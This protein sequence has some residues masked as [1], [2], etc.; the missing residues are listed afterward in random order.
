MSST[1][2]TKIT[3]GIE[4]FTPPGTEDVM[5]GGGRHKPLLVLHHHPDLTIEKKY[6][7]AS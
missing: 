5:Q 7:L 1:S 6:F 2:Q 3:R 4:L